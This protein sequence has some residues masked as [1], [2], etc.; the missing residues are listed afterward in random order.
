MNFGTALVLILYLFC[1]FTACAF[2]YQRARWR[3]RKR[4]GRKSLGFCPTSTSL[5]NALHHLMIIT[6]P[7]TQYVLEEKLQ[8]D[9]EDDSSG[10]PDTPRKHLHRQLRR[11]RNGE[12][13][14]PI[15]I[16]LDKPRG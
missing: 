3:R 16:L 6:R 12:P 2:F 1:F 4:L 5:G 7:T 9:E 8:E 13:I 10:D 11:I 14:D 15:T